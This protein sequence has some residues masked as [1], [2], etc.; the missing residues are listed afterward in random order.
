MLSGRVLALD[1]F[2]I[3]A[4]IVVLVAGA[5][6]IGNWLGRRFRRPGAEGADIGT[7]TAAALGLLAL[8]LAFSFSIALSRF[9]AR[10]GMVLDEANAIGSAAN[11]ARLLPQAEQGPILGLLRDYAAVRLALGDESDARM[12]DD[13][14][15][16]LDLQTKLWREAAAASAAS[17][18]SLPVSNFA[19]ALNELTNIHEARLTNLRYHVPSA[20]ILMLIGVAMVA[21]GFTG[22]NSGAL[23]ARRRI[24]DLI[25]SVTIGLLIMLVRDL[26][27][28]RRGL[29]QVPV[30]PLVDVMAELGP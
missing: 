26:D 12:P 18:Q 5:A 11:F 4:G 9:D 16:S 17:P 13:I 29:S 23:G 24:P 8:L 19:R 30:Q 28:P 15:R 21:M 22:Y 10:R 2:A 14:A 6:E 7:L 3:H 25:M 20:V 27:D 1:I